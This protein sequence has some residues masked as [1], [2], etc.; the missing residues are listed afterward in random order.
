MVHHRH[1]G[2]L[3]RKSEELGRHEPDAHSY[4]AL[5]DGPEQSHGKD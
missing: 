3:M 5:W 2:L 4:V 1:S